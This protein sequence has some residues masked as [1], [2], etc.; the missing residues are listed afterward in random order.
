MHTSTAASRPFI[1]LTYSTFKTRPALA[2]R[3][4][5]RPFAFQDPAK[6]EFNSMAIPS[7][8]SE[9]T[10]NVTPVNPV[11]KPT[12]PASPIPPNPSGEGNYIRRAAALIIG[13]EILNGK[14]RDSNSNFFARY[15]F[16]HGIDLKRVEV[17]PDN[18]DEIIEASRRLVQN[19][20]FVIT[21]GG[22]GPTHDGM[23]WSQCPPYP[24]IAIHLNQPYS[25]HHLRITSQGFR[26]RLGT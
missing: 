11:V 26:P 24:L 19:Y 14:T 8:T 13:D 5:L 7:A 9:A 21:T 4:R 22:I 18:E 2:F 23:K 1:R 6:K 15:C 16:E 20:D 25:R 12:Y 10:P 3:T 17:I